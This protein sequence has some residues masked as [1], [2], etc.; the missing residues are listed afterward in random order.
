MIN[1]LTVSGHLWG[2]EGLAPEPNQSK[3]LLFFRSI[4]WLRNS[5]VAP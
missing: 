5:Q 3:H 2:H 1:M 4:M